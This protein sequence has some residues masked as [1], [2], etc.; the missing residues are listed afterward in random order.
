MVPRKSMLSNTTNVTNTQCKTFYLK[1]HFT[2]SNFGIYAAQ[3]RLCFNFYVGQTKI[4]L[5][6]VGTV[7]APLGTKNALTKERIKLSYTHTFLSTL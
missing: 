4:G 5:M 6:Y 1:Q 2:C 7:T 3:C